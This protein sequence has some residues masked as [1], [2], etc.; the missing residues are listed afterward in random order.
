MIE[1]LEMVDSPL[2]LEALK[3]IYSSGSNSIKLKSLKAM[4]HLSVYDEEFLLPIMK[5]GTFPLKKESFIILMRNEDARLKALERLFSISSFFGIKN[6]VL[7]ENIKIIEDEDFKK[8]KIGST[9]AG[10]PAVLGWGATH[11]NVSMREYYQAMERN[12]VDGLAGVPITNYVGI[13]GPEVTKFMVDHPYFKGTGMLLMNL[14]KWKKLPSHLQ[15]L[16]LD[17]A[18]LLEKDQNLWDL[19]DRAEMRPKIEQAGCKI[20]QLSPD[21]AKWL[22]ETAYKSA[23][24][25]QQKRF[26]EI[27]PTLKKFYHR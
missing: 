10:R 27:T 20:Y 8:L 22:V 14:D 15:K 23:W 25:Y 5:K 19:Q 1:N 3:N 21:N 18:I 17:S 24:E 26:P 16:M 12:L 11:V 13:G 6:R 4:E 7:H 2:S 9:T